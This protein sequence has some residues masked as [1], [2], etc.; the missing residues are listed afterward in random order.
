MG[1]SLGRF[2]PRMAQDPLQFKKLPSA[3]HPMRGKGVPKAVERDVPLAIVFL[4]A[5]HS[6]DP[7]KGFLED[8]CR[9]MKHPAFAI[10]KNQL[11]RMTKSPSSENR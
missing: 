8:V 3:H 9:R 6:K 5:R 4:K 11:S 2:N 1:V 7:V 10:G